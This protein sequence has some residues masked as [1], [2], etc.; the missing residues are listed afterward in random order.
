MNDNVINPLMGGQAHATQ[1]FGYLAKTAIVKF[2]EWVFNLRRCDPVPL[3]KKVPKWRQNAKFDCID[4][5]SIF[6]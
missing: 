2:T 4:D 5:F 1:S 3:Q 6:H